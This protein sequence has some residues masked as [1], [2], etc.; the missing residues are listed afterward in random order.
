MQPTK[1]GFRTTSCN[2][3]HLRLVKPPFRNCH[4]RWRLEVFV[5]QAMYVHKIFE[6]YLN[7][8]M[9]SNLATNTLGTVETHRTRG[10]RLESRETLVL[11]QEGS[12]VCFTE[13]RVVCAI[14]NE[15][16]ENRRVV[17]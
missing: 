13:G 16:E 4:N 6:R 5:I 10:Q 3:Q 12:E 11:R 17:A 9:V 2:W 1:L 8:M 7:I 14:E 15:W